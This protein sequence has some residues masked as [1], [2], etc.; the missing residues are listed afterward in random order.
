MV[1]ITA[2]KSTEPRS[3]LQPARQRASADLGLAPVVDAQERTQH[4]PVAP[5]PGVTTTPQ[6]NTSVAVVVAGRSGSDGKPV[7]PVAA[8]QGNGD[9][10]ITPVETA[11]ARELALYREAERLHFRERD[12]SS[13]ILA[14]DAYLAQGGPLSLEARYNR[15]LC[16]IRLGRDEEAKRELGRFASGELGGY[17]RQEA[18][19]LLD[20]I[21]R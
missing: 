5:V 4:A 20:A 7:M 8:P 16:L 3:K 10:T 18:Q 17:R 19:K 11:A 1:G 6:P 13:A 15:S 12:W 14:W 2:P 9:A 21:S